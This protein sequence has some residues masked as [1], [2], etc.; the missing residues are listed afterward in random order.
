M[1]SPCVSRGTS[2]RV[3]GRGETEWTRII[4]GDPGIVIKGK[5][6]SLSPFFFRCLHTSRVDPLVKLRSG[7]G[8]VTILTYIVTPVE[9][10]RGVSVL[11]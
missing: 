10:S 2:E 7:S 3:R 5:G 9:V 1:K 11:N 8:L 6:E 4:A